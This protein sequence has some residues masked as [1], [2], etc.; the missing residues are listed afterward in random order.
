MLDAALTEL[1]PLAPKLANTKAVVA[2][3]VVFVPMAAVGAD[4]IPIK[5]GDIEKTELPIPVS[6]VTEFNN[7]PDIMLPNLLPYRI[8]VVGNVTPVEAMVVIAVGYLLEKVSVEALVLTAPV[9]PFI[10]R[11]KPVRKSF[12]PAL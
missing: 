6:S 12:Q 1:Y 10:G 5:A 8:P 11:T 2:N 3:C 9:P 4:G 7:C